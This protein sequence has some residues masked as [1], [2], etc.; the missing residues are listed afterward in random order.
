MSTPGASL[1]DPGADQR[2]L[3]FFQLELRLWRR[4][5]LPGLL[6]GD[7]LVE[8]A[9][10]RLAPDD[11][12]GSIVVGVESVLQIETQVRLALF[13]IRSVAGI[14]VVGENRANVTVEVDLFLRRLGPG[15]HR[16]Q[17]PDDQE[18]GRNSQLLV[19]HVVISIA[20]R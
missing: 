6:C 1:F 8:L 13:L 11:G 2:H 10:A 14:A 3:I 4:H 19:D 9:L 15:F 18:K 16:Q 5:S 20:G 12:S 7:P 17:A